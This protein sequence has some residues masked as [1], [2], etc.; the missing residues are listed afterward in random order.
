MCQRII[1]AFNPDGDYIA[2]R[3]ELERRMRE[4]MRANGNY[5]AFGFI[6]GNG[7]WLIEQDAREGKEWAQK[8]LGWIKPDQK[9]VVATRPP[10]KSGR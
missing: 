3:R 10:V 4:A 6:K 9:R 2:G 8:L 5:R 1:V 7:P